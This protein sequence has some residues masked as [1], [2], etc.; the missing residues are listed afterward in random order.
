MCVCVCAW[1]RSRG[2]FLFHEVTD[3]SLIP[4]FVFFVVVV[5]VS[6]AKGI[7][8][9]DSDDPRSLFGTSF[10]WL[11]TSRPL[12]GL[13]ASYPWESGS[14][15][16]Y[17]RRDRGGKWFLLVQGRAIITVFSLPPTLPLASTEIETFSKHARCIPASP[18]YVEIF[19]GVTNTPCTML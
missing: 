10:S 14:E 3:G 4:V 5:G 16:R 1:V 9:L 6:C 19:E 8:H 2:Q 15:V 7:L 17:L 11:V 12:R 18:R 13:I